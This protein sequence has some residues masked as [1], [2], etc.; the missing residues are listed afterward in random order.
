[1][2]AMARL[3]ARSIWSLASRNTPSKASL[4]LSL[5]LARALS[6][7]LSLLLHPG[8]A[9]ATN[10][11]RIRPH[12]PTST[13]PISRNKNSIFESLLAETPPVV[14]ERRA[15]R[16]Q[17]HFTGPLTQKSTVG[18]R[19]HTCVRLPLSSLSRPASSRVELAAA[20]HSC[21]GGRW[22]LLSIACISVLALFF[23]LPLRTW[24]SRLKSKSRHLCRSMSIC[25]HCVIWVVNTTCTQRYEAAMTRVNADEPG[26]YS[27]HP[28]THTQTLAR[29]PPPHKS[30]EVRADFAVARG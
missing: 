21:A 14:S 6:L 19:Q 30:T 27:T 7:S 4:S 12:Q 23:Q 22:S 20:A 17:Q 29:T 26:N 5:S 25:N 3:C 15:R 13:S 2:R 28:G 11:P 9:C 10:R 16:A 18:Q 8:C 24:Q 1:M